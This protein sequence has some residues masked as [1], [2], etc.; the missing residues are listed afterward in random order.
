VRRFR[1]TPPQAGA[2]ES[3]LANAQAYAGLAVEKAGEVVYQAAVS[4]GADP[5]YGRLVVAIVLTIFTAVGSMLGWW[6]PWKGYH[7]T[8]V[9]ALLSGWLYARK[10]DKVSDL[11][12]FISEKRVPIWLIASI[13]MFFASLGHESWN[14]IWAVGFGL[15]GIAAL[16]TLLKGWEVVGKVLT[17]VYFN[18]EH[19]AWSAIA[20]S[21]SIG[22][23]L[24]I[25][26][27]YC[28]MRGIKI[29]PEFLSF[30][31]NIVV[32][33]IAVFSIAAIIL[34][35]GKKTNK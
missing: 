3:G 35:K 17:W 14:P 29:S 5:K 4:Y 2:F 31:S 33:C 7:L 9:L 25:F 6:S 18:K 24:F 21:L 1:N 23:S 10:Y 26:N 27:K 15:S 34:W 8:G 19:P 32:V 30:G 22:A 28:E 20:G 11:I 16:T 13:L 12:G